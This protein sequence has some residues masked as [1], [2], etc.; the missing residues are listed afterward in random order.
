MC[1]YYKLD[2]LL[3]ICPG[4]VLRDPLVVLCL[5][6]WGTARLIS[7]VVVP[8]CNPTS[9]GGVF[10]FLYIRSSICCHLSFHPE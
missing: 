3:G 2:H 8:A 10:L 7:R 1:P 4:V 5:I 6:F 9:N